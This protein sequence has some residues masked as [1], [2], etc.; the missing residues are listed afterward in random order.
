MS[1]EELKKEFSDFKAVGFFNQTH[2]TTDPNKLKRLVVTWLIGKLSI[3]GYNFLSKIV[4]DL[5][6]N[7]S[8]R[9][10]VITCCHVYEMS[11]P[12]IFVIPQ[13]CL[14]VAMIPKNSSCLLYPD[15]KRRIEDEGYPVVDIHKTELYEPEKAVAFIK[16]K[17]NGKPFYIA[18]HGGY[19]ANAAELICRTFDKNHFLGF[20]EYTANGEDRYIKFA[21]SIDRPIVSIARSNSKSISDRSSGILIADMV[22]NKFREISG[23]NLGASSSLKIGVIGLG[24]IGRYV[25][26]RFKDLANTNIMVCEIDGFRIANAAHQCFEPADI[27]EIVTECDIIQSANGKAALRNPK[28]WMMMKDNVVIASS[29]SADDELDLEGLI[30]DGVIELNHISSGVATYTIKSNGNKVHLIANGEAANTLD[31]SGIGD[32]TLFLPQALQIAANLMVGN[33]DKRLVD[34]IQGLPS[35]I[36]NRI[37][38][39]WTRYFHARKI[40]RSPAESEYEGIIKRS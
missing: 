21:K 16:S 31:R 3:Q 39:A 32:A 11:L 22:A 38:F 19:F 25:A 5:N 14:P 13:Y 12:D 34:G 1:D 6:A 26:R 33:K 29:T 15:I 37:A 23:I 40:A 36:E 28:L 20:T 2:K 4:R 7:N 18:D 24:P 8:L 27:E 30:R 35:D 17:T 9:P 10:D